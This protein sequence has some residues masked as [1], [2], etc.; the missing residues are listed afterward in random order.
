MCT[1]V[2]LWEG[3][4]YDH[5]CQGRPHCT[6]MCNPVGWGI[7]AIHSRE[8]APLVCALCS[9]SDHK[10]VFFFFFL[11]ALFDCLLKRTLCVPAAAFE[12]VL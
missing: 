9:N 11:V 6:N 10:E 3:L 12:V 4:D 1:D 5:C 2:G 7:G 8:V